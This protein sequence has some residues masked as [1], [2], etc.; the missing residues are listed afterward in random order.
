MRCCR[1]FASDG[2]PVSPT[3]H[4]K[5]LV[6]AVCVI[7]S[8]MIAEGGVPH[9][10]F[11]CRARNSSRCSGDVGGP[12]CKFCT[13]TTSDEDAERFKLCYNDDA[14]NVSEEFRSEAQ[15]FCIRFGCWMSVKNKSSKKHCTAYQ[16]NGKCSREEKE[17]SSER[18]A[19]GKR[20]TTEEVPKEQ[21]VPQG[22][23]EG[24]PKP[25]HD[26]TH[27]VFDANEASDHIGRVLW[28][29]DNMRADLMKYHE[30]YVAPALPPQEHG[31]SS[32]LRVP[33]LADRVRAPRRSRSRSRARSRS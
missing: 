11:R 23:P 29:M 14:S 13:E 21:E 7:M 16:A 22:G 26:A 1:N 4:L 25:L 9:D 28:A 2:A 12:A 19:K 8:W 15:Y 10:L 6:I 5:P 30:V 32:S 27:F 33:A 17:A 31:S 24:G 20:S 3:L 18:R